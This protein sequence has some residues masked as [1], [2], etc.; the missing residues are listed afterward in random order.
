MRDGGPAIPTQKETASKC[1]SVCRPIGE[2][3]LVPKRPILRT[4]PLIRSLPPS[5]KLANVSRVVLAYT[6]PLTPPSPPLPLTEGSHN[7][8]CCRN[9]ILSLSLSLSCLSPPFRVYSA[10]VSRTGDQ[11]ANSHSHMN[12]QRAPP[13][14]RPLGTEEGRR[15]GYLFQTT[16][17]RKRWE[18]KQKRGS[19]E[20]Q[21]VGRPIRQWRHY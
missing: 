21:L 5:P 16:I 17:A 4:L 9:I 3:Q 6:P 11:S 1:M 13:C 12:E 20:R 19:L 14:G 15:D 10:I 8:Q 7:S 18:S 2:G